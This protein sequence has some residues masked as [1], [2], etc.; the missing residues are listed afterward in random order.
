[1]RFVLTRK[2]ELAIKCISYE[3]KN[4]SH[5]A[6]LIMCLHSLNLHQSMYVRVGFQGNNAKLQRKKLDGNYTRMLRAI[7]NKSWRQHPTKQQLYGHVLPVTKTIKI[8]RTRLT[9]HYCRCREKAHE[10]CTPVDP[11]RW[12]SKGR[13]SSSNLYTAALCRYRM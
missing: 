13:T 5:Q 4:G 2:K 9:G 8:R 10:W 1:M 6:P 12:M 3:S 11:F 7:L